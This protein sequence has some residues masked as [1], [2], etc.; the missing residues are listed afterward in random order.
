M[1]RMLVAAALLAL[2]AGPAEAAKLKLLKLEG[3]ITK[4]GDAGDDKAKDKKG[5]KSKA[6]YRAVIDYGVAGLTED[7]FQLK[8]ADDEKIPPVPAA[9]VDNFTTQ[10]EDKLVLV[11]MVQGDEAWMGNESYNQENPMPGGFAGLPDAIAELAKGAP[12]GSLGALIVF[13]GDV[14]VKYAMGDINGVS[15]A[16]GTQKNYEGKQGVPLIAGLQQAYNVLTGGERGRKVLIVLGDGSDMKVDSGPQITE[17]A[18]KL[19]SA[20]I[21]TFSVYFGTEITSGDPTY[22]NKMD[23]IGYSGNYEAQDFAAFK[24]KAADII[25]RLRGRY[26]VDF[27]ADP[28]ATPD[29]KT[30]SFVVAIE[31]DETEEPVV[32]KTVKLK[33]SGGGGSLWWLW[34][35][36]LPLVLIIIIV[37]ILVKRKPAPPPVVEAPPE[38]VAAAPAGP[39]KT[40]MLGIGGDD[41]GIPIVGWIVPLSGPNQF[42]TFKLLAGLTKVGTGGAAHIIVND[43]FMSIEHAEIICSPAGFILKDANSTNGV[44]VNQKRIAAHELVDNDVFTLGRTDFKFKSIN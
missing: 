34:F 2:A 21:E 4:E 37:I 28:F 44:F 36:V 30:R 11:V 1:N 26:Y 13:G 23:S 35:I 12:P 14:S 8:D 27:P 16:L 19:K 7:K 32:L 42:Q 5:A 31:K 29:E 17:E 3:P 39:A 20:G 43:Q 15:G 6:V 24:S 22:K 10:T 33:T 25:A 40:V 41:D 18:A 38:P 9:K